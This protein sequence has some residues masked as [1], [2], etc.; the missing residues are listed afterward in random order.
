MSQSINPIHIVLWFD[1][2]E[3]FGCVCRIPHL[4]NRCCCISVSH[5]RN[6][7]YKLWSIRSHNLNLFL[8][9]HNLNYLQTAIA[10]AILWSQVLPKK[11][12]LPLLLFYIIAINYRKSLLVSIFYSQLRLMLHTCTQERSLDGTCL[13]GQCS[14]LSSLQS[15][16]LVYTIITKIINK[17]IQQ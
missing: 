8:A 4:K 17:W 12:L 7:R 2:H 15:L 14:S 9:Q 6:F 16:Q 3:M 13:I 1:C 11:I 10:S 5:L